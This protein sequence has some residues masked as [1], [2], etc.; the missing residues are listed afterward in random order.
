A[1]S[2]YYG[3]AKF[4]Q[5][6]M[7]EINSKATTLGASFAQQYILQK[8]FMKL[9]KAGDEQLHKNCFTPIDV[10]KLSAD[11]KRKTMEA[12][13]FLTEK[14]DKSI[15]GRMVYSGKPTREWLSRED[16]ASPTVALESIMLTAIV[17][18]KEKLNVM[19]ADVP[20]AFI[21]AQ[22]HN[23][24][25]ANE[26]VFMKITGVLINLLVEMA[27]EVYKPFV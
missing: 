24:D 11:E 8:G 3:T 15:K 1:G 5:S 22:M 27:P 25:D 16:A 20:N 18:A 7:T 19:T 14:R 23:L 9:K 13:M 2:R 17:D 21:Q 26:C 10:T 6:Y 12:L 4:Y